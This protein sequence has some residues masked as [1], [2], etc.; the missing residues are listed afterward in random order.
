M[1]YT[2]YKFLQPCY[3]LYIENGGI[4]MARTVSIGCQ[5]FKDLT[6]GNYFYIDKTDFI[7]EWWENRDSVTL[8]TRPRRFGKT[9]AM[10]MIEQFFSVKYREREDLFKRFSIWK[11]KKYRALQGT[12]PIIFLSFASIKSSTYT[13]ARESLA[14]ILIDLYSEFDFLRTSSVLNNIEKEY[15]NQVNLD[16][17]DSVMQMALK[18]LSCCLSKHYGK[19]VIIL[20]DEYDTPI[21][22]AWLHGFW[23][24]MVNLTRGLFNST[25]KTNPY[26]ERGIMTGI[27]RVSKE[28]IFLILTILQL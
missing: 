13:A 28:S 25:F 6:E 16:M 10:S 27:T 9:L 14:F 3:N 19:K 2:F 15:F 11:N 23:D 12:Y 5:N 4:C 18:H 17:P 24:E 20:L 8:I 7:K 1:K 21:Q 26:L 22:E